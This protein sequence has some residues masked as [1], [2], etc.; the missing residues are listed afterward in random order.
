[1]SFEFDTGFVVQIPA[2]G[3]DELNG[4][5]ADGDMFVVD[6]GVN[7]VVYEFDKDDMSLPRSEERRAGKEGRSRWS[8]CQ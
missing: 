3:A 6:D 7:P 1:M 5:I 4:G 2:V 8:P